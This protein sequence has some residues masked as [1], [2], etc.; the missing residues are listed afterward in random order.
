MSYKTF[1]EWLGIKKDIFGWDKQRT[2]SKK[3]ETDEMPL[4]RFNSRFLLKELLRH[5]VGSRNATWNWGDTITWGDINESQALHVEIS[6][7]G[8]FKVIIRKM[9][10]SLIGENI[11]I[12]KHVH[13]LPDEYTKN[14]QQVIN[15]VIE[16]ID[17]VGA[18]EDSAKEDF[19]IEKLTIRLAESI[20]SKK[21]VKIMIFDKI[22]QKNKDHYII[23]MNLTGSGIEA[24]T[25]ARVEQFHIH[26]FFDRKAGLIRS[27]GNDIQSPVRSHRWIAQ[28]AEWDENF[29]PTQKYEEI[30]AAI[31]NALSTY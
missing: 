2:D 9:I 26:M 28:P 11:W 23:T 13:P 6:P 15:D 27:I 21:P 25:R 1:N 29:A 19:D 16:G 22:K 3:V 5:P 17:L 7:L 30:V 20:K 8:S 18:S 10:P 24:P 12:C 31:V 4:K 14:E